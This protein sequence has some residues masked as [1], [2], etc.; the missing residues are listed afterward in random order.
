ME[1]QDKRG[2]HF[3]I[4]ENSVIETDK[5]NTY[6]KLTYIVLCKFGNK[7]AKTAKPSLS[8]IAK[9]VGC[10]K[11]TVI[12][13]IKKL[14]ALNLIEVKHRKNENGDYTSNIYVLLNVDNL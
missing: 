8:T 9:Y 4:I 13:A 10:S 7:N 14:E 2:W 6:E 3:T 11:P 12:K 5:L 1:I